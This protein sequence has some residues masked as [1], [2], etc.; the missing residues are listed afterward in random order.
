MPPVFLGKTIM[1]NPIIF[2]YIKKGA[3][4]EESTLKNSRIVFVAKLTTINE[5][6][7]KKINFERC[8]IIEV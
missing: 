3:T 5:N 8:P 4:C 6:M 7:R 1:K 2:I